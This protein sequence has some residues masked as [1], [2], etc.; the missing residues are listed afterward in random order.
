MTVDFEDSDLQ[1]FQVK[2]LTM[3]PSHRDTGL[4]LKIE[5]WKAEQVF[6]ITTHRPG[7]H[8]RKTLVVSTGGRRCFGSLLVL[9]SS[10]KHHTLRL[11]HASAPSWDTVELVAR[12]R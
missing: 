3:D 12:V 9:H 11:S 7:P 2:T 4:P 1:R 5:G 10:H 8:V 6:M